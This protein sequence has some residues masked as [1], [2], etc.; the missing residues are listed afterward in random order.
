MSRDRVVEHEVIAQLGAEPTGMPLPW[1]CSFLRQN[2]RAQPMAV[3]REM[4]V[5]GYVEL[6]DTDGR[7]L[8]V[9]ECVD[10]FRGSDEAR[11]VH[12]RATQHGVRWLRE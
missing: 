5:A 6:R 7:T 12:V 2:G 1:L 11:P 4:W 3:L 9:W 8:L 10:V